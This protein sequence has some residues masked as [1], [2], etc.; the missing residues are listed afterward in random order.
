MMAKKENPWL[1]HVK[2]TM[3]KNPKLKFK[4]VLKEAKKTYKK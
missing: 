2:S 1:D 3:K 4:D